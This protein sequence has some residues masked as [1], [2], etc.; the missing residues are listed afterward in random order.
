MTRGTLCVFIDTRATTST[1]HHG[2]AMRVPHLLEDRWQSPTTDRVLRPR[3]AW[4]LSRR[5]ARAALNSRRAGVRH[6]SQSPPTATPSQNQGSPFSAEFAKLAPPEPDLSQLTSALGNMHRLRHQSSSRGISGE[7]P[8][9]QKRS[10]PSLSPPSSAQAEIERANLANATVNP[11]THHP[12]RPPTN[13]IPLKRREDSAGRDGGFGGGSRC[14]CDLAVLHRS[15]LRRWE[16][17]VLMGAKLGGDQRATDAG[18]TREGPAGGDPWG[19]CARGT[20]AWPLS[21][22]HRILAVRCYWR[23][24]ESVYWGKLGLDSRVRHAHGTRVRR[25]HAPDRAE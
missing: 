11:R 17:R 12:S 21:F 3:V 4:P 8:K 20:R 14:V 2:R 6:P 24:T 18:R 15:P 19:S 23:S 5:E 16:K 13:R 7:T 9:A 25:L 22:R 10:G 1:R